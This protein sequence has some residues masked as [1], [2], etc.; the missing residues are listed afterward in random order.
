MRW[1][2]AIV[3]VVVV[4]FGFGV[5]ATDLHGELRRCA[6][7]TDSLQRLVCYD[8]LAQ[9]GTAAAAGAP[10]PKGA[11]QVRNRCAAITKKGTQ[12]SRRPKP[13]S[14]HCWQHGG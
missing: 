12:C 7:I 13:G 11:E 1:M 9:G 6:G 10:V 8:G 4:S 5:E 3:A 14:Q 2:R